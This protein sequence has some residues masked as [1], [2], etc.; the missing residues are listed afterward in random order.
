MNCEHKNEK[1]M[2]EHKDNKNKPC[3]LELGRDDLC[4]TSKLFQEDKA[5]QEEDAGE[6]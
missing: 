1:G 3:Y 4:P 2:C 6:R 5:I